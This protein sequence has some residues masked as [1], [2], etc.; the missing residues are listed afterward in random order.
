MPKK[1]YPLLS[2][3]KV[4]GKIRRPGVDQV[5]TVE[6][7]EKDAE[8]LIAIGAVGP[9]VE[10]APA[11]AGDAKKP[12]RKAPSKKAPSNTPDPDKTAAA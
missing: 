8:E 5:V 6:L 12:S 10:A 3:V 7:D 11:P 9:A 2:P 1:R 4:G